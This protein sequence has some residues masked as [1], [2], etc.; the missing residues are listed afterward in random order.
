MKRHVAWGEC[1]ELARALPSEPRGTLAASPRLIRQR[2]VRAE[3]D[4]GG[5]SWFVLAA[6]RTG[7]GADRL[8]RDRPAAFGWAEAPKPVTGVPTSEKTLPGQNPVS[9]E[10]SPSPAAASAGCAMPVSQGQAALVSSPA[11][12][13]PSRPD[14]RTSAL[15]RGGTKGSTPGAR[16]EECQESDR[17]GRTPT[18]CHKF[19]RK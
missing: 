9:S 14:D 11:R 2:N 1:N 10:S 15:K 13:S 3:G 12:Q 17:A 7:R 18:I 4:D 16:Q 19:S 6:E 8:A 5:K